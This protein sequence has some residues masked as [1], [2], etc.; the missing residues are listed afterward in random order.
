MF[1]SKCLRILLKLS[2][3]LSTS[4]RAHV[5]D[6]F[7]TPDSCRNSIDI[8]SDSAHGSLFDLWKASRQRLESSESTQEG[9]Q[10]HSHAG[11]RRKC[12]IESVW[13]AFAILR[14][15]FTDMALLI[16]GID[17]LR[18]TTLVLLTIIRGLLPAFKGYSQALIIDE[19]GLYKIYNRIA[20][21]YGFFF[22]AQQ[23]FS[24]GDFTSA[25][26]ARLGH[27]ILREC[28]RM[29]AESLFDTVA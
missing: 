27:L 25:S 9:W 10:G 28:G 23:L 11:M 1:S 5:D 3:P 6:P 26:I 18:I 14:T 17:P 21:E 2:L 12:N 8:D 22:K 4:K 19:V 24:K 29:V 15:T 16:W 7:V 13:L 20:M